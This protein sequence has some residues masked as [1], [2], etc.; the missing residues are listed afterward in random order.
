M[1]TSSVEIT[2]LINYCSSL[3]NEFDARRNRVRHFVTDHNLTSG[4]ANEAILRNFLENI[5]AK[6][7]AVAQGF[8]CNPLKSTISY[9]CDILIYDQHYPLVHS[10]GEV[11]IVWPESVLMTVEV[12]TSMIGT[13]ELKGAIAN[14]VAAK[15]TEKADG[16]QHI[17]GII[18]AFNSLKPE[19]VL[20]VLND[21]SCD[22]SERPVA[23]FLFD[24]GAFIQQTNDDFRYGGGDNPYELR[25]CEGDNR[26]GLV[27][28]Y[29]LL[30]FL[31][32]QMVRTPIG[33]TADDL[34]MAT[35]KFLE[36]KTHL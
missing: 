32:C 11:K 33:L 35:H 22:P 3:A 2:N 34:R 12:K 15:K 29:F 14:I 5:S 16:I 20:Q 27:L 36:E 25:W 9:Q 18:F 4:T 31:K 13:D 30:L 21:Y 23:V 26:S 6:I 1:N 24:K 28:T 10:E 8:I 19:T 7:Y 17:Q